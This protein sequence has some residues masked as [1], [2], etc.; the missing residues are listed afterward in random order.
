[1]KRARNLVKLSLILVFILT[2]CS[3]DKKDNKPVSTYSKPESWLSL[4]TSQEKGVDVFYLYPTAWRKM[5][6]S[7]PNICEIDNPIMLKQS[8][9]AFD[10]QATAF[11]TAA[12][13]YAPYYRQGDAPY[14]LSLS[15]EERD[16]F[17]GDIPQSDIFKAFD[18]YIRNLNEGRPFILAGHSQGS[19]ILLYLLS[20]YMQDN[21]KVYDRMIAAYVIGYSVTEDYMKSNPH[22]K[23]AEGSDDTGVIVSYNTEAP[24]VED[25]GNPVVLEGALAINPITWTRESKLA[26]KEENLGSILLNPDGSVVTGDDGKMKRLLNYA[27]AQIDKT[28]GVI[29]CSTADVNS[30]SPGNAVFGKGVYHLFDYSFYYFNIRENAEKRVNKW[31]KLLKLSEM[32]L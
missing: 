7:E 18:Y 8:K 30:L 15:Q 28:K 14:T 19:N 27:D 22:L 17:I 10:R 32:S 2:V 3:C 31:N 23:F 21:P 26:T 1:M 5:D 25:P 4:P 12:N 6:A 24:S 11:E 9:L 13:I 29:I 20:E 16:K